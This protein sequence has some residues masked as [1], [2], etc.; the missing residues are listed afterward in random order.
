MLFSLEEWR[1]GV[2]MGGVYLERM[3]L[4]W[5]SFGAWHGARVWLWL[6]PGVAFVGRAGV[7]LIFSLFSLFFPNFWTC[8][9]RD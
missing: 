8:L 7:A 3:H 9:F 6:D 5:V 1:D 4:M 2:Y